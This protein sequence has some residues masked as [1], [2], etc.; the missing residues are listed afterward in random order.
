MS[1]PYRSNLLRFVIG[2]YR[3]GIERHRRAVR[4][5]KT[6]VTLAAEVGVG[7]ALFPVYALVHAS[8]VAAQ[9]LGEATETGRLSRTSQKKRR[10]LNFSGFESALVPSEEICTERVIAERAMSQTLVALVEQLSRPQIN[11]LAELGSGNQVD[12]ALPADEYA[13]PDAHD[14]T[15]KSVGQSGNPFSSLVKRT[16]GR[17]IPVL[18]EKGRS[19]VPRSSRSQAA[20]LR[21]PWKRAKSL[22]N[23]A[24]RVT[25]VASDLE[26][27]SLVLVRD[28]AVIWNGLSASQQIQLQQQIVRF[29]SGKRDY[30]ITLGKLGRVGI[31]GIEVAGYRPLEPRSLDDTPRSALVN[32]LWVS[33][34]RSL[35][36][37]I[38]RL[39]RIGLN[40]E[41]AQQLSSSLGNSALDDLDEIEASEQK[42]TANGTEISPL[43]LQ[44]EVFYGFATVRSPEANKSSVSSEDGVDVHVNRAAT[45]ESILGPAQALVE[46][47]AKNKTVTD[48]ASKETLVN[49]IA[50]NSGGGA[51]VAIE[52][53][54]FTIGYVEHPLEKL[55]KWVDKALLWLE[56]QW[57]KI[58][59]HLK[60]L[61]SK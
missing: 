11:V 21:V 48:V 22:V 39:L 54:S 58:R 4:K 50:S 17:L 55:L 34:V 43:V 41:L 56:S 36:I 42:T 28:Y 44:K 31:E 23:L 51:E 29:L 26:T 9:K 25:G 46:M 38:N 12:S 59:R 33:I 40:S 52:A 27:R 19:L 24:G 47:T 37:R 14:S 5:T 7:V 53:D 2:Q 1:G 16:V 10:L 18:A 61:L 6:S 13:Y 35:E 15:I 32:G 8:Q 45:P 60:R 49:A 57:K 20:E 30:L 3:D